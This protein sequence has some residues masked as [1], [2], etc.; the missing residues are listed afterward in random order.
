MSF[1]VCVV[2]MML[3]FQLGLEDYSFI[4]D[5]VFARQRVRKYA[6]GCIMGNTNT[7]RNAPETSMDG[8]DEK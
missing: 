8:M 2:T 6:F 5:W 4:P 7:F 1:C 3:L